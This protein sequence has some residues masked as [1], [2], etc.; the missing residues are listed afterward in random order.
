MQDSTPR[1]SWAAALDSK[2]MKGAM[3][4]SEKRAMAAD[5]F[6]VTLKFFQTNVLRRRVFNSSGRCKRTTFLS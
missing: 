2:R 5:G 4:R 1:M 6:E 3:T